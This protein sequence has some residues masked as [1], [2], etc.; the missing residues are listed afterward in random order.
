MA[1]MKTLEEHLAKLSP[2]EVF[3]R[4]RSSS[5]M[6]S[7]SHSQPSHP[8]NFTNSQAASQHNPTRFSPA[9]SL[10]R[11]SHSQPLPSCTREAPVRRTG[12]ARNTEEDL[13]SRIPPRTPRRSTQPPYHPQ[14]QPSNSNLPQV[15]TS[16]NHATQRNRI[17][18]VAQT[19]PRT[20]ES[21]GHHSSLDSKPS[22]APRLHRIA[23]TIT[24]LHGRAR[25]ALFF[26]TSQIAHA[27]E[28]KTSF[29]SRLPTYR[30][31]HGKL[32][33]TQSAAQSTTGESSSAHP[34][35]RLTNIINKETELK[36]IVV[37][38]STRQRRDVPP[39]QG[40]VLVPA[41]EDELE[42]QRL[43][44]HLRPEE[45][46]SSEEEEI[47]PIVLPPST[48]PS[49]SLGGSPA[50]SDMDHTPTI[51]P[52]TSS[53]K[54]ISMSNMVIDCCKA[55][56]PLFT[57]ASSP[58]KRRSSSLATPSPKRHKGEP[59]PSVF[60]KVF[61]GVRSLISSPFRSQPKVL[62][63]KPPSPSPEQPRLVE[64]SNNRPSYPF[65][66]SQPAQNS[67]EPS[68]VLWDI[69][70]HS[71]STVSDQLT[72]QA[73]LV[74]SAEH[75]EKIRLT[76]N[77]AF[78]ALEDAFVGSQHDQPSPRILPSTPAWTSPESPRTS[79]EVTMNH[80]PSAVTD[81]FTKQAFLA[82]LAEHKEKVDLE[83]NAA[84]SAFGDTFIRK[85]CGPCD[86]PHADFHGSTKHCTARVVTTAVLDEAFGNLRPLFLQAA[87]CANCW[88]P[89]VESHPK[90]PYS[91]HSVAGE[92]VHPNAFKQ[93]IWAV[94][95]TPV[96]WDAFSVELRRI[97]SDEEG[98]FFKRDPNI[99][100]TGSI[101]T[102]DTY[103]QWLCQERDGMLNV[104]HLAYW[105]LQ[106][107]GS[108][109][110]SRRHPNQLFRRSF[111]TKNC[112]EYKDI[113]FLNWLAQLELFTS[114]ERIG[115]SKLAH[116]LTRPG[117]SLRYMKST[118][119]NPTPVFSPYTYW[120]GPV[121]E[122]VRA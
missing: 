87:G 36:P 34:I 114:A 110:K 122:S 53:P 112:I 46:S 98:W 14:P 55:G 22:K 54:S 96:L 24:G 39:K 102:V 42:Q 23:D 78:S 31:S 97:H 99:G 67:P 66:A 7:Q 91:N 119:L 86:S 17:V 72:K 63:G 41:S 106:R 13:S 121:Q 61:S 68:Q 100:N 74:H 111:R 47:E 48:Q 107:N 25:D 103:V 51:P 79:S 43:L 49:Q 20:N 29:S 30:A 1:G 58:L 37:L 65:L 80:S 92:C 12:G 69:V 6:L 84:F 28:K 76:V 83:V 101:M 8:R 52:S 70:D 73:L 94:Y 64:G 40:T 75:R 21:L 109:G 85:V 2:E 44:P 60:T 33:G 11:P 35:L 115:K 16:E 32:F 5:R 59:T 82:L 3:A 81:R 89:Y 38:P 105:L 45:V 77:A 10:S 26:S 120:E 71:P 62:H 27:T 57:K 50:S 4:L 93:I 9:R 113:D 18:N 116:P 19:S 117:V 108:L 104:G 88:I 118:T 56:S 15:P 95:R 90:F